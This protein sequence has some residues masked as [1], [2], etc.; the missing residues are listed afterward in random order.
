M[1]PRLRAL[2]RA[3]DITIRPLRG[4]I[5]YASRRWLYTTRTQVLY[6]RRDCLYG[7]A[8]LRASF[9]FGVR[10]VI[11]LP[12]YFERRRS[13]TAIAPSKPQLQ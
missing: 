7:L 2:F 13:Y 4:H 3:L 9:H 1:L 10:Q 5:A 8:R 12:S 6:H 11:L